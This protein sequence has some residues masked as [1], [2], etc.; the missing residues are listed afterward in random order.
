MK[1]DMP[2]Q[3]YEW[4]FLTRHP[5]IYLSKPLQIGLFR[6]WIEESAVA[7][8]DFKEKLRETA[9]TALASDDAD[10]IRQSLQC[11]AHVGNAEDIAAVAA[12][13]NHPNPLIARDARTCHFEVRTRCK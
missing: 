11:L 2:E 7:H 13:D 12:F 9:L 4:H 8:A 1:R 5:P 10:L 6:K 3:T